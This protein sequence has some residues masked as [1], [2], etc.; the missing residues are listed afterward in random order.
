MVENFFFPALFFLFTQYTDIDERPSCVIPSAISLLMEKWFRLSEKI[1]QKRN[2]FKR[3]LA[4]VRVWYEEHVQVNADTLRALIEFHDH[5]E[6]GSST[7][8][9]E[10]NQGFSSI[11]TKLS[12]QQAEKTTSS[13][14]LRREGMFSYFE[15]GCRLNIRSVL[16]SGAP[17]QCLESEVAEGDSNW[18]IPLHGFNPEKSEAPLLGYSPRELPSSICFC[19][20]RRVHDDQFVFIHQRFVPFFSFPL[21][22]THSLFLS[23]TSCFLDVLLFWFIQNF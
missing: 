5:A 10:G 11:E 4:H 7:L 8:L 15:F 3:V 14:K 18:N 9:D 23:C 20:L 12:I 6:T 1:L 16:S 22:H 13:R 21:S 2:H 17:L 19:P